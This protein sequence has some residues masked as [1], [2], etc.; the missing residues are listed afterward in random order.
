M[1]IRKSDF[2][3]LLQTSYILFSQYISNAE[4]AIRADNAQSKEASEEKP[5]HQQAQ[6]NSINGAYVPPHQRLKR[7]PSTTAVK[8][9]NIFCSFEENIVQPSLQM[10][11]VLALIDPGTLERL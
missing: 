7:N 2:Q 11:E 1:M 8:E 3:K 10:L 6:K 5:S 4:Y 9:V